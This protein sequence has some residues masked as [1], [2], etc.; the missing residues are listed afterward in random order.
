M[1]ACY[2][3]F[4]FSYYQTRTQADMVF[5]LSRF[6]DFSLKFL[7][8]GLEGIVGVLSNRTS[9]ANSKTKKGFEQIGWRHGGSVDFA[10]RF[11]IL[12]I[13][14]PLVQVLIFAIVFVSLYKK[15]GT[16]FPFSS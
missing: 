7:D 6:L 1:L 13:R 2:N 14:R 15:R 11:L 10:L 12:W 9:T 4:L 3:E 5:D 16:I 8:T